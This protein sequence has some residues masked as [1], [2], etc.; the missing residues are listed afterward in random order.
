MANL[1]H[2]HEGRMATQQDHEEVSI[3]IFLSP[4][5]HGAYCA[6][7]TDVSKRGAAV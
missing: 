5:L 1:I 2:I 3:V 4:F 7:G 6:R